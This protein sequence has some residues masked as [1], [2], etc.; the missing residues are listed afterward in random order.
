[1][2]INKETI[3]VW[4]GIITATPKIGTNN[5]SFDVA[6]KGTLFVHENSADPTSVPEPPR[7]GTAADCPSDQVF[8]V[9]GIAK[10]TD[11]V[12]DGNRF[13]KYTIEWNGGEGWEFGGKKHQDMKH[14]VIASLQWRGSPDGS[15]SLCFGKGEDEY[16]PFVSLGYMKPGNR[17]TLARR[18]ALDS[19]DGR[20]GWSVEDVQKETIKSI[21]D[22]EE[23]D[24]T[25]RPPWQS[26]V[27]KL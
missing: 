12:A 19:S 4:D 25:V 1:M 2:S 13:K 6:W 21:Y 5:G 22:E 10:P 23:E 20:V 24:I 26:D 14:V 17:I 11:G 18:C 15:D 27:L 16:G 3:I 7:P 9:T 8:Q